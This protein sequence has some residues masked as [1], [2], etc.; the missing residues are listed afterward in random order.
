MRRTQCHS[1]PL[2][3]NDSFHNTG[4]SVDKKTLADEGRTQ[5]VLAVHNSEFNCLGRFS[6]ASA[7]ACGELNFIKLKGPD[8]LGSFKSPTLRNVSLTAPYMH[9]G[10]FSTLVEVLSHYNQAPAASIG[11]TDIL[12]LKFTAEQLDQL[13]RFLLTLDSPVNLSAEYLSPPS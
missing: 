6:D 8:L 3:S 1:G 7:K 5:G 2:L 13:R 9:D 11:I 4:L 10:R 12:P